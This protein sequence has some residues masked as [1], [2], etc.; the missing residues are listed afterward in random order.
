VVAGAELHPDGEQVVPEHPAELVVTHLAEVGRCAAEAGDAAHRVRCRPAA[1][2]D[3][4]AER[5]VELHGPIGLDQ[6][7]PTLHEPVLDDER[8]V[9][10]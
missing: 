1:H 10:A 8:I 7:H 9:G 6:V 4:R 3:G 5:L 2:L